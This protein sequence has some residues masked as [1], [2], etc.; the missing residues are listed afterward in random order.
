M[1]RN[2]SPLKGERKKGELDMLIKLI[3]SNMFNMVIMLKSVLGGRYAR[4]K[5]IGYSG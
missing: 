1:G 4:A 5:L 2:D 3:E